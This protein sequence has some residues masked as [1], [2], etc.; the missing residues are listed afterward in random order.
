MPDAAVEAIY[1]YPVKGLSAEPLDA[2]ELRP[3][4]ALPF[5]RAWAMFQQMTRR[6]IKP[7]QPFYRYAKLEV[8]ADMPPEL[9]EM[10]WWCRNPADGV[11]CGRCKQCRNVATFREGA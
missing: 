4:E 1:R 2:V 6:P 5:D 7:L 8:M 9:F 10:C 3:G 11:A